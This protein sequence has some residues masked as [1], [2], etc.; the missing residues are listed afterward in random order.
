MV[1]GKCIF[2]INIGFF[3]RPP[4]ENIDYY[5]TNDDEAKVMNGYIGVFNEIR[6]FPTDEISVL[7]RSKKAEIMFD[8]IKYFWRLE[9]KQKLQKMCCK[10]LL[11]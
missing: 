5:F 9:S 10:L 8:V 3:I 4:Y 11:K 6:F 2:D 1:V 7:F